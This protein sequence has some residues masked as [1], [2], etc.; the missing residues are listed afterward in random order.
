MV[1][2]I[3]LFR[4][5]PNTPSEAR[6]GFVAAARAMKNHIPEIIQI[7]AGENWSERSDGYELGL[8]IRFANRESLAAYQIHPHHQAFIKDWVKP[9]VE[10][11]LA[12]DY[13]IT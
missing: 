6:Q 8:V 11:V 9:N 4:C 3:V 10:K 12:V 2:H 7:T 1:E 5:Q 13:F